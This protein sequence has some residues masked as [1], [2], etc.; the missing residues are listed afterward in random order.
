[1]QGRN[2]TLLIT[3]AEGRNYRSDATLTPNR[4]P[5]TNLRAERI[6]NDLDEEGVGIYLDNSAPNN[7][8]SYFRYEYEETYKIIAPRWDPFEM[9]V[10][11]YIACDT[12]PYQVDIRPRT[13]EQRTCF[14]SSQSTEVIQ[15]STADLEGSTIENKRIRY[16]S[17]DNYIIS[18]RYSLNVK[19][20]SQTQEA[21]LFYERLQ[22]FSSSENLFS[23]VQP[24]LLEGNVF[25]ETSS[26]EKVLGYFEVASVSTERMYF[27][28]ADLFPGES[29]PPYAV[30]CSS[31]GNPELYTEG[32]GCLSFRN[33]DMYSCESPLIE[34]ILA[35]LITFAGENKENENQPYFTWP[36]PCGDCTKLGSNVVPEFWSE[37]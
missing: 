15:A 1:M 13:E 19:Q 12:V 18:H 3:T 26:E 21:Y 22:E 25:S 31:T 8:P 33:C 28:Y 20:F 4:V 17:R 24:G 7:T 32:Y 29:L 10:V 37:E 9:E 6:T 5:I 2:Y 35:G 30:N 16:L 11:H 34:E 27:N 36:S 14:A 23:Q